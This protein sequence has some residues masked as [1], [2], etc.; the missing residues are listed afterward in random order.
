MSKTLTLLL[1]ILE[2]SKDISD[3]TEMKVYKLLY[4]LEK[5]YYQKYRTRIGD[6][7]MQKLAH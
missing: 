6:Q 3:M 4:F 1:F 2:N 5:V 7:P